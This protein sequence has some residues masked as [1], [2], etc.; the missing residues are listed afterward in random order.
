M[1]SEKLLKTIKNLCRNLYLDDYKKPF[2]LTEGQA[3]IF[4]T[5]L[6]RTHPR[7]HIMTCTQYGKSDVISMA[8]LTRVCLFPERW[9]IV[10]PRQ[11]QAKIIMNYLIGHIFDSTFTRER[12]KINPSESEERIQRERNKERLTFKTETGISEVFILSAEARRVGSDAGNSLMGFGAP[13]LVEDESSLIPDQ[14]HSKGMRML[15]GHKDN[16]LVKIGNPFNRN[17]FLRSYQN[18]NYHKIKI[19]Y[20]QAIKEG[21]MTENY[22]NEMRNESFFDILYECKFPEAGLVDESGWT[23]LLTD[24]QLEKTFKDIKPEGKKRLGVDVGRGGDY[25]VF[26]V[27]T[28]NYAYIKEKNRDPDLMAVVGKVKSI[29]E[30]EG[31]EAK[32]VFIDDTGVGAGVSDRLKE[33]KIYVNPVKVG[34]KPIN[35]KYAN[36]KAEISWEARK[37]LLGGGA[38]KQNGDWYQLCEIRYKENSSSKLI[39]EPKENLLRKGLGSPDVAD[40]FLLTFLQQYSGFKIE[41]V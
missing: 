3:E 29:M 23:A 18:D 20:K 22:I 19:D 37:W 16:F 30:E 15:G 10:A 8:V 33:Q 1:L 38:L 9:A 4:W 24:E 35:E 2:E 31:I 21:R 27:R 34:G 26:I 41:F 6:K 32:N 5:I 39:I 11:K 40:A 36:I 28:D 14:V 13:N 7:N 17:H 12:F 25:N